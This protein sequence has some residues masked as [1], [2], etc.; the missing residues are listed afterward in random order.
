MA[1]QTITAPLGFRVAA[2]KA[3]IKT[4]GNLDLGLIVADHPCAAA[5]TFTTNKIFGAAVGVTREH[6]RSGQAR[7]V[8]VNAGNANT[9]TGPRGDRDARKI[10]QEVA[11]LADIKP[12]AVLICSTGIIGHYLPMTKVL[13]GITQATSRLSRSVKSGNN[14]ARAIMTTDTKPKMAYRK[15]KLNGKTVQIAGTTKG[16]GMIAPNMATMLAFITTDASIS[17]PMLRRAHK[18]AVYSTFNKVT[19]D[20]HMSTSDTAIVLAS[21]AADNH[22]IT[23]A[24]P[25]YEKFSSALTQVCDDL[26]LQLAADGE[27]AHCTIII[28]VKGAATARDARLAVRAISDSPLVKTAFYGNDP[29]WGR[30]ISA[31]GYSGAKFHNQKLKCTIAG[32]CVFRNGQPCLFD[33]ASLSTKMKAKKWS[34]DVDLGC[35]SHQDFCY[36]CDLSREYVTINADYHT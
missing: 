23:T 18:R 3:G 24:D 11:R 1:N 26:A 5:A 25:N 7:A 10:C 14:F 27:G 34:V 13:C 16:S 36:T 21:G 2:V 29:N 22:K 9:C 17:T 33:P 8:F 15:I 32:T 4:S 19:I 35:G 20:N 30:I 31:I 6:I 12:K 28:R